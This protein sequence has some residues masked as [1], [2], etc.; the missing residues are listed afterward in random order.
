MVMVCENIET[1]NT[2][3]TITSGGK[4]NLATASDVHMANDKGIVFGDAGEKIEGD[5]TNLTI[6]S[7]GLCTI[8]A[9]GNTV[10]Y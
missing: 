4:I 3:F 1:D 8:T 5:G 7:S 6:S 10:S 2:D 9:T